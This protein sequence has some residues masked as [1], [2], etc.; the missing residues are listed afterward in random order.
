MS[1]DDEFARLLVVDRKLTGRG[2]WFTGGEEGVTG[3]EGHY[4]RPMWCFAQ[5][6]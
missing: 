6:Q 5:K 3:R 2:H 4:T 1:V